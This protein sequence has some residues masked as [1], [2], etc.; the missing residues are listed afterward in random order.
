MLAVFQAT[1]DDASGS[2]SSLNLGIASD[3]SFCEENLLQPITSTTQIW[4][5]TRHQYGISAHV[6]QTSF[7]GETPWWR[8]EMSA[9]FQA[10]IDNASGSEGSLKGLK[11]SWV[12]V[13]LHNHW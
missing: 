9:V 1:I 4:V 6:A 2:E 12:D 11:K 7:S 8:R 13:G 3:W 10:T 5:V